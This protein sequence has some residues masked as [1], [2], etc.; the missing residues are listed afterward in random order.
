VGRWL[1][2]VPLTSGA[3]YIA[4][5]IV[6][7]FA[8][9]L[10]LGRRP[11]TP[12]WTVGLLTSAVLLVVALVGWYIEH[13]LR[14][15]PDPLPLLVLGWCALALFGLVLAVVRAAGVSSHTAAPWQHRTALLT[16]GLLVAAWSVNGINHEYAYVPNVGVLFGVGP[17]NTMPLPDYPLL[18][19]PPDRPRPGVPLEQTW[20]APADLP[21]AGRVVEKTPIPGAISGFAARPAWVYLPPAYL[22]AAPPALPVM[23]M[24]AGQPGTPGDWIAAGNLVATLDA[25][26]AAHHGLA[27]IV[28]M[29]DALGASTANPM[30]LDS[31]LGNVG[32]YL[33]KDVPAWIRRTFAVDPDPNAWTIGGFSYG[34]TCALQLALRAPQV[35]RTFLN[36]SG[37]KEPTLG[38][39]EVT[40]DVAF[41]G[42]AAK[43][44]QQNPLDE[45]AQRRYPETAGYFVVGA[46]DEAVKKD[47]REVDQ[48][49]L[50]CGMHTSWLELPGRHSWDIAAQGLRRGLPWLT[51]RMG[52]IKP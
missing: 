20:V 34:G 14:P 15:F 2:G 9:A 42:D 39:R 49:A 36:V 52:L 33:G 40:V 45:M 17:A 25:F 18:L 6:G 4:L 50:R 10:L 47:L 22:V 5:T 26:A 28:V 32:T 7:A 41:G 43:F 48:A 31:T 35:Y 24:L 29:P 11:A 3:G 46:D 21:Q 37:Q 51:V 23:V 1:A 12:W 30:C 13:V 16:A 8:L 38:S 27:P 44:T 19:V